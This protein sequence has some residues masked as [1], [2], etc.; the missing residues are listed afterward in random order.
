MVNIQVTV[1]AG[2]YKGERNHIV[3]ESET[4]KR[5]YDYLNA[6][7]FMMVRHETKDEIE[8]TYMFMNNEL[9][10]PI[11]TILDLIRGMPHPEDIVG[12][13]IE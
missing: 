13:N 6:H 1:R 8:S 4:C 7:D 12:V 11:A 3:E 5:N 9:E 10:I 2:E